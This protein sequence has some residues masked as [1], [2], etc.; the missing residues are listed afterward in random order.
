MKCVRVGDGSLIFFSLSNMLACLKV[1]MH[2]CIFFH[3]FSH[4][5]DSR[6]VLLHDLQSTDD[7]LRHD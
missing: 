5:Y 4:A 6:H 1:N 3:V 7:A 2:V